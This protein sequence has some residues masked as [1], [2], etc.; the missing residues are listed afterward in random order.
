MSRFFR[1]AGDS[2]SSESSDDDESIISGDE[3]PAAR[4]AA[5]PATRTAMDRFLVTAGDSSDSDSSDSESS[6]DSDGPGSDD[7]EPQ[8]AVR[9]MSAQERRLVEME[10]TGKVME[11]A[12]KINDWVAI[13]NGMYIPSL[14]PFFRARHR[15]SQNLTSWSA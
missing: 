1:N 14:S 11:N 8:Q 15:A 13:S 12:L 7:E 10:A 4:P 3:A 5:A 9:I 2:D 6:D